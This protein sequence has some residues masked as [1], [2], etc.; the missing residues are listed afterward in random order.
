MK[1]KVKILNFFASA[2]SFVFKTEQNKTR[3]NKTKQNK[4]K[5]NKTEQNRTKQNKTKQN[6]TNEKAELFLDLLINSILR[7][8]VFH[9]MKGKERIFFHIWMRKTWFVFELWAWGLSICQFGDLGPFVRIFHYCPS[10]SMTSVF[11]MFCFLSCLLWHFLH[12]CPSV[13]VMMT[14]RDWWFGCEGW[15]G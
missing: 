6:K 5:Q 14:V 13:A 2:F 7:S 11:F 8:V 15:S 10:H 1:V 9:Q 4:T 12:L 3:Q